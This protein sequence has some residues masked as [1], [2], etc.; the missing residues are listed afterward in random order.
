MTTAASIHDRRARA[1]EAVCA[2]ADHLMALLGLVDLIAAKG[3]EVPARELRRAL[4]RATTALN[5]LREELMHV[6]IVEQFLGQRRDMN[7]R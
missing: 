5:V 1:V 4:M 3:H 2:L 7:T 6:E